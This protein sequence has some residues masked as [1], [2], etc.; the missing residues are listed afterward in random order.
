MADFRIPPSSV[1]AARTPS[2][3]APVRPQAAQAAQRAFFQAATGQ[4][5][6]R[7]APA[8]VSASKTP[9]AEPQ[10]LPRPGSFV[11]IKV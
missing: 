9:E 6:P 3:V 11:D 4:P 7:A 8:A 2:A 5:A 10:R 1:P